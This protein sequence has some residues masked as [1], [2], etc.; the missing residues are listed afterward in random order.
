MLMVMSTMATGLTIKLMDLG[1]IFIS[2]AP[3]IKENGKKICNTALD[4]KPGQMVLNTTETTC[5]DKNMALAISILLTAQLTL[6]LS[7]KT[8]LKAMEHTSSTM[9]VNTA[10][11]G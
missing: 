11:S 3:T 9:V 10:V 8:S 4:S 2:M 1:I 6:D 5:M 7:P